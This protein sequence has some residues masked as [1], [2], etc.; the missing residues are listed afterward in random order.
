[1]AIIS[2]VMLLKSHLQSDETMDIWKRYHYPG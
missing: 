1:M 2:G